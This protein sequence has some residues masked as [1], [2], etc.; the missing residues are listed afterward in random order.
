[1]GNTQISCCESAKDEK[2]TAQFPQADK[3]IANYN[4]QEEDP[5]AYKITENMGFNRAYSILSKKSKQEKENS[6]FK[7]GKSLSQSKFVKSPEEKKKKEELEKVIFDR[8]NKRAPLTFADFEEMSFNE[9]E[10]EEKK[11]TSTSKQAK[12]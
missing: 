4:Q 2:N 1:M 9:D 3:I 10:E 11:S 5:E 12:K 7:S 8:I 6:P